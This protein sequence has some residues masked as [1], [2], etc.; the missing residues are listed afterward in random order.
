MREEDLFARYGGEEF[1]LML[2]ESAEDKALRCAERCREAVDGA[3]F[4][5]SGTPIKVTISARRRDAAATPTSRS[6][7]T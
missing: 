3:D 1:A 4:T 7:R 2:R 6:P 5:F